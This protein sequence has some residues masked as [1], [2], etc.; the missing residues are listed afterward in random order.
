MWQSLS[1]AIHIKMYDHDDLGDL[2]AVVRPYCETSVI[3]MHLGCES[4][5]C[6][7]NHTQWFH[8][9]Y[10]IVLFVVYGV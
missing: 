1:T 5:V 4:V 6:I 7:D 9:L 10:I 8:R 3:V 2:V